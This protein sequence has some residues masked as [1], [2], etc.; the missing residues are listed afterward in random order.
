MPRLNAHGGAKGFK[1][2]QVQVNGPV[3][4]DATA[5]QRDRCLLLAA[6]QRA[7]DAHR[8][9]HLAHDIVRR[10]GEDLFRFDRD[11]AAGPLHFAA[12][13]IEDREHIMDVAKVRN[14]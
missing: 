1:A 10:F 3:S 9:A 13:L 7:E 8:G 14:P 12:E 4:D 11:R 6:E 2:A 5:W